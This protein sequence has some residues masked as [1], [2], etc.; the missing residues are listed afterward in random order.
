M[1]KWFYV[2]FEPWVKKCKTEEERKLRSGKGAY[3]IF[4][5]IYFVLATGWGWNVLK[6]EPWFPRGLGGNVDSDYSK[7]WDNYPY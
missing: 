1:K 4:K 5:L 7:M 2:I 3:N 6:D